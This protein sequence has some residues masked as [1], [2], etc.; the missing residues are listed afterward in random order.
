M[1]NVS[2]GPGTTIIPVRSCPV[3]GS[4][5]LAGVQAG[6]PLSGPYLRKSEKKCWS[7]TVKPVRAAKVKRGNLAVYWQVMSIRATS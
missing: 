6:S 4:G 1:R 2:L 3:C 7:D 5:I